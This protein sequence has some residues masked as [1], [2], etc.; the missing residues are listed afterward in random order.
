ME[1]LEDSLKNFRNNEEVP[2]VRMVSKPYGTEG[3]AQC[4]MLPML[5]FLV[6]CGDT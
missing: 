3:W 6:H 2:V 5:Y 4:K 1:L